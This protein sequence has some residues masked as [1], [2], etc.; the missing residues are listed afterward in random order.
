MILY[1]FFYLA[2]WNALEIAGTLA[3]LLSNQ[4]YYAKPYPRVY[5]EKLEGSLAHISS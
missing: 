5:G 4:R 3:A 1:T 2:A